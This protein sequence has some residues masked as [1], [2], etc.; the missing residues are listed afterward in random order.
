[1]RLALIAATCL[2]AA[3]AGPASKSPP[4]AGL[5]EITARLAAPPAQS[6]EVEVTNVPPGRR[7]ERITLIDPEGGRHPAAEL[8]TVRAT[9]GGL[10]SGPRV[11]VGVSGGSSSGISPSIGLGWNVT[12]SQAE[13]STQKIEAQ[14]PIPDPAAYQT[15]APRWRIE[16]AFTEIEG[17][18]RTLTF[19]ASAN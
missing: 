3:C 9:E 13:R 15:D 19:P 1:M 4:P 16:I 17:E 7:I 5:M 14:V 11:G 10:T 18:T 8:V 2:L 12:G 6:V